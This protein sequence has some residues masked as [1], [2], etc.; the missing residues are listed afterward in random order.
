MG[1]KL[2]K[3]YS[4]MSK[5]DLIGWSKGSIEGPNGFDHDQRS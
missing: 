5:M 4:Q 1:Q 2:V 3:D